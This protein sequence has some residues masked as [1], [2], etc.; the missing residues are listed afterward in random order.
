MKV[1][2]R[3]MTD[4]GSFYTFRWRDYKFVGNRQDQEDRCL[5]A[6]ISR[7][8]QAEFRLRW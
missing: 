4:A 7:E 8:F 5:G 6:L 3:E 2:P 1:R